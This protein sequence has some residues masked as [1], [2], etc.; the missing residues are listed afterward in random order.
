MKNNKINK[1]NP[2]VSFLVP[3]FNNES[4]LKQLTKQL[5]QQMFSH[6]IEF[7][8][9]FVNDFS[10]DDS[11]EVLKNL[12]KTNSNLTLVNMHN[13]VGQHAAVFHG[14]RYINGECCIIM[15][16][17]LQDPPDSVIHLIEKRCNKYEAIFAG[18]VGT[19]QNKTRMMTSKI[20]KYIIHKLTGLPKNAG[21][22]MLIE[23]AL[24]EKVLNARVRTI[25][26]NVM[27]GLSSSLFHVV[28]IKRNFRGEGKSSY[29][30]LKRIQS[31]LKG[32]FC[33]LSFYIFKPKKGYIQTIQTDPVLEVIKP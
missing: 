12:M 14:L 1:L 3:V 4:S 32:I 5:K 8:I 33:A 26:I 22:F 29:T 31:A 19:Y 9:I 15:D 6:S 21:I 13:N 2:K 17:D 18:R 25:W 30:S 28:P 16:A 24:I 7:E 27:V 11:L 23:K 20:Y 10:Q